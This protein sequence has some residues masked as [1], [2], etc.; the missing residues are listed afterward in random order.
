MGGY[1]S[2]GGFINRGW[3]LALAVCSVA[4]SAMTATMPPMAQPGPGMGGDFTPSRK[5][6][7]GRNIR[8]GTGA[9]ARPKKRSNRR[10][11]SKRVRRKHRRAK[12]AA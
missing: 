12:K 4:V 8:R 5:R 7:K 1:N 6:G 3:S 10:I 9:Q 2:G 11:I